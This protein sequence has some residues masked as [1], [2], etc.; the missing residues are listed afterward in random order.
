MGDGVAMFD[1]TPRLVAWNSK[2]QEFF[3]VPDEFARASTGPTPTTSVTSPSAAITAQMP[4]SRN[5]SAASPRSPASIRAYERVRPDGRVIE[6]RHNPV[7][8]AASC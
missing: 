3:D 5:R 1:E 7:P 4:M 8:A 2:F 6:I